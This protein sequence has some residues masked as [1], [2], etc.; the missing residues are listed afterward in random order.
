MEK[1]SKEDYHCPMMTG[2]ASRKTK[3]GKGGDKPSGGCTC[4]HILRDSVLRSPVVR[5]LFNME[6]NK[7]KEEKDQV[8]CDWYKYA[9]D[10]TNSKLEYFLPYDGLIC[11]EEGTDI[12]KLYGYKICQHAMMTLME[13]NREE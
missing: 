8:I 2:G 1:A 4:L 13:V 11:Q 7:S 3:S 10:N 12:S 5:Y 9:N 6:R